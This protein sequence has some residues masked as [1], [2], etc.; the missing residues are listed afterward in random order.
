MVRKRRAAAGA[1]SSRSVSKPRAQR[2]H[3]P[4]SEHDDGDAAEGH[5]WCVVACCGRPLRDSPCVIELNELHSC[6]VDLSVRC[7][8]SSPKESPDSRMRFA[9]R[10][11]TSLCV[12]R[13]ANAARRHG[14]RSS[15]RSKAAC[16][17]QETDRPWLFV[18]AS[19]VVSHSMLSNTRAAR[20]PRGRFINEQ[21]R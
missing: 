9:A 15:L 10:R 8:H 17:F 3:E 2:P 5:A 20:A 13:W 11:T 14:V 4:T 7:I 18:S 21:G 16:G 12:A 6:A 19:V 1:S